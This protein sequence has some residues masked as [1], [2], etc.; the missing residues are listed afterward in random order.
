VT[1]APTPTPGPGPLDKDQQKCVKAMN[2]AGG[3]VD[4]AQ[5]KENEKCLKDH[6]KD[7]LA[8][9]VQDCL[10]ADQ[11]GKV[12]KKKDKTVKDDGKKCVPL[13]PQ[14]NFGYTGAD[15]VNDAG[16]AGPILVFHT[17]FGQPVDDQD[18]FT[19]AINKDT[20]KCQETMLKETDKVEDTVLKEMRKAKESA[21]KLASVTSAGDLGDAILAQISSSK[22]ITKAEQK[23][24]DQVSKKCQF[25]QANW[26]VIF[27]GLC[28]DPDLESTEDCAIASAR[29]VACVKMNLFDGLAM[30]CDM[31]DNNVAD[32]SCPL[33]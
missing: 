20:A 11:K 3:N 15:A 13:N 32:G 14:P 5:L 26:D 29:C 4:K 30:P 23:L 12:Q 28:G 9:T 25:L 8:G 24:D 17:L 22:A 18:L 2:K 31:V 7:K 21:I 19:K 33:P 16:V 1:P 10:T 27:P 6:Q